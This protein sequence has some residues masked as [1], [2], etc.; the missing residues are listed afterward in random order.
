MF[1]QLIGKASENRV[2]EKCEEKD[3]I[4]LADVEIWIKK[5]K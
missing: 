5:L 1:I 2:I 3:K 4:I